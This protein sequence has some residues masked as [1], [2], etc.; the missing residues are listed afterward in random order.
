MGTRGK[1]GN[2]KRKT[3]KRNELCTAERDEKL[4]TEASA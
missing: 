1:K 3:R 4:V 2:K